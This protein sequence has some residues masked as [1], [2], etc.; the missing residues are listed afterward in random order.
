MKKKPGLDCVDDISDADSLGLA[1]YIG[2]PVKLK[3]GG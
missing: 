3:H 2:K 1:W